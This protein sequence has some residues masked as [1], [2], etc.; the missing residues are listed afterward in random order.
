MATHLILATAFVLAAA[1]PRPIPDVTGTAGA[2]PPTS[3]PRLVFLQMPGPGG[4][5]GGGGNRQP[6]PASR[7]QTIGRD[8]LAVPVARPVIVTEAPRDVA[9]PMQE[10]PLAVKPLDSGATFLTG[11][12][13]VSPSIPASQGPGSGG[14]AGE[15]AGTGIGSG[16]GPGLGPGSGGGFGG[17]AYRMGPGVVAPTL[18]THVRP[19]YTADA[20]ELKLQGT[21]VLEVVVG[22]DGIP[23][24]IRVLRSLDAGLDREAI[25]AVRQWRFAPGRVGGEPVD[26]L[27]TIILDFRI[28]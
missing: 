7:A 3:V 27:V 11:L 24:A 28:V 1:W 21:V 12:P 8:R 23:A 19:K 6:A 5:G 4:G 20:L 10:L 16:T 14:G 15:G 17:G 22:R 25:A 9:P 26:V 13:D 18:L 2:R